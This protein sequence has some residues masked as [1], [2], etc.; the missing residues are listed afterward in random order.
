MRIEVDIRD[1]INP[2]TAL[3]AVSMVVREGKVSEGEHGKKYYCWATTFDTYSDGKITVWTRQYRK[4]DCFTVI[5][6][7]L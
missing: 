6:E 7:R 5:R 4:N 2:V 1:D 3:Q